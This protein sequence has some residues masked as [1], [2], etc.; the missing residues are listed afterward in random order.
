MIAYGAQDFTVEL[1]EH[2]HPII[3]LGD[4]PVG[5]IQE[6]SL[7]HDLLLVIVKGNSKVCLFPVEMIQL[8]T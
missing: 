3:L 7:G 1:S 6:G 2:R 5:I 4:I 8:H